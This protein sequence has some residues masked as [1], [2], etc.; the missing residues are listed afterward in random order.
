MAK[1]MDGLDVLNQSAKVV[2]DKYSKKQQPSADDAAA[3]PKKKKPGQVAAMKEQEKA[4]GKPVP[5][6]AKK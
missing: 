6:F 3:L 5:K 2:M 4:K 1:K